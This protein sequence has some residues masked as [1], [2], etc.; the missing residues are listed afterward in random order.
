M[1]T[2]FPLMVNMGISRGAAAAVWR[3]AG[4]HHPPHL[5]DVVMAAP[6]REHG[7]HRVCLQADPAHFLVAI[8]AMAVT[9]FFWQRYLDQK[10][11]EHNAAVAPSDPSPTP[12]LLRHPALH[13]HHRCA[14]V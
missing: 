8:A 11:G 4:R 2:L 13:P 10:A 12:R 6:G 9:H 3:L 1:A 7:A 5:G 14:A